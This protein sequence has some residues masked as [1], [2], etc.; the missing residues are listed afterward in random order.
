MV[1]I[2]SRDRRSVLGTNLYHLREITQLNPWTVTA[3]QISNDTPI[4]VVPASDQWRIEYLSKLLTIRN[5]MD[6]ENVERA[7][8]NHLIEGICIT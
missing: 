7:H 2:T 3:T 5:T 8:I 1:Q 6:S 4:S